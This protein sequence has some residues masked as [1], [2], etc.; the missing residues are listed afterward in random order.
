VTRVRCPRWGGD[1][2]RTGKAPARRSYRCPNGHPTRARLGSCSP[3]GCAGSPGT[4]LQALF[5]SGSP[6]GLGKLLGL[7]RPIARSSEEGGGVSMVG[8]EVGAG[9]DGRRSAGHGSR[10]GRQRVRAGLRGRRRSRR[11]VDHSTST[12]EQGR[13]ASD[14]LRRHNSGRRRKRGALQ[15]AKWRRCGACV[16]ERRRRKRERRAPG[17]RR[18]QARTRRSRFREVTLERA[19]EGEHR[20]RLCV[21]EVWIRD[22]RWGRPVGKGW[23]RG[24]MGIEVE[25][26]VRVGSYAG[27]SGH[28]AIFRV[29]PGGLP[30]QGGGPRPTRLSCRAEL[31]LG[32]KFML[33]DG[34]LCC[35][36]Y[37]Q[38]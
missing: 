13:A 15:A 38:L 1:R 2:H 18:P 30:C 21:V 7:G 10:A 17:G 22:R 12:A 25:T 34:P 9:Q 16:A 36:L 37:E 24:K 14:P 29:G 5:V 20:L 8:G 11:G 31:G 4:G 33:A 35:G 28:A 19:G 26:G 6:T 32:Q 27:L 23:R 3:A